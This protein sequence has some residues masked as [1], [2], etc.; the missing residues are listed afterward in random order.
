MLIWFILAIV[1]VVIFVGGLAG[2]RHYRGKATSQAT[3][4]TKT[5]SKSHRGADARSH[6]G[7]G[8]H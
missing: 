8:R 6:R 4:A 2:G 7:R 5:K 3:K 1:L